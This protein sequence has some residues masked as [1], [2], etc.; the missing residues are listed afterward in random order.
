ME[1]AGCFILNFGYKH[2]LPYPQINP[3]LNYGFH[4]NI[5]TNLNPG[6]KGDDYGSHPISA[7]NKCHIVV[8]GG[9]EPLRE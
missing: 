9:T 3:T 7:P 1:T 5:R 4:L 2:D 8:I 6:P